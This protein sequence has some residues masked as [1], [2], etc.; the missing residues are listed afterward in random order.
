[1]EFSITEVHQYFL[2]NPD[3]RYPPDCGHSGFPEYKIYAEPIPQS[4]GSTIK[5]LRSVKLQSSKDFQASF[6]LGSPSLGREFPKINIQK[7]GR[8]LAQRG[9]NA[10]MYG[11]PKTEACGKMRVLPL[12]PFPIKAFYCRCGG[13]TVGSVVPRCRVKSPP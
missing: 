12:I 8:K 9:K 11:L 3:A 2:Y 5:V 7:W 4:W 6:I 10:S 13:D 1:M